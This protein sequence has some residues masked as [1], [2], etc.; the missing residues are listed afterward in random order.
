MTQLNRQTDKSADANAQAMAGKYLTFHLDQEVF[1]LEIMKVQ[2]IIG[3]QP[4]T[5]IP[6]VPGYVRGIINLRGRIVPVIDLRL[7]FGLPAVADTGKSCIIVVDVRA[8]ARSLSVGLLV[9]EVAEV[10]HIAANSAEHVSHF[11]GNIAMEYI[12]GV[13]V[14]QDAVKMLLDIDKVMTFEEVKAI[15]ATSAVTKAS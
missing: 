10:L 5:H 7:R 12:L 15:H 3:L 13:G 14:V 6:Q 9:D 2:E 1:G 11:A 4:I 8:A